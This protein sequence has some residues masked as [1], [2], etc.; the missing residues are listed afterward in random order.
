MSKQKTQRSIGD[1][2]AMAVASAIRTS[3]RK[4]NLVAASI[5]GKKVADAVVA[6]DYTKRRVAKDVKRVLQ[7]AVANAENNHQLDVD[8]LIVAEASV[9]RSFVMK[10]WMARGRG[11][12]AG[13]EKPFSN[14]R[15][16][17]KESDLPVAKRAAKDKK[18]GDKKPKTEKKPAAA[19][20]TDAAQAGA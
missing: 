2:S 18:A 4:L 14:L 5:R 15:V 11:K 6:L 19:K 12:S 20:K 10:R 7:A 16:I 1:D 3:A 8:K 13:V 17:V 9:G